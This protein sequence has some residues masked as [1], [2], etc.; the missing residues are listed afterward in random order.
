MKIVESQIETGTP[1]I[2]YKDAINRKSGQKNLGVIKSSNLCAE[3]VE[4]SDKD[5]TAVCN[6]AS[7]AVSN[8][9]T[10]NKKGKKE[11]NFDK[12]FDISKVVA[13][14]IDKVIDVNFYP[15]KEAENSNLKHRPI[16]IGIQGLADTLAILKLPFESKDA[17]K[18]NR[19]IYETIYFGALTASNELAKKDG[20]YKSFENSPASQGKLQFDL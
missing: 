8:F 1:Y 3:I 18:L 12:L 13:R 19:E 5:E 16:G 10:E 11:F 17:M 9:I 6:L 2:L 15:T 7:I 4:Y 14:N 20:S